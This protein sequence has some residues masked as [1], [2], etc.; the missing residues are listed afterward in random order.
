M[1]PCLKNKK[2]LNWGETANVTSELVILWT[3]FL[4]SLFP[5]YLLISFE[6]LYTGPYLPT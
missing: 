3:E 1:R 4:F 5:Y 2:V 6:T